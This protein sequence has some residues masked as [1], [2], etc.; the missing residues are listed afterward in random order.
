MGAMQEICVHPPRPTTLD[1]RKWKED[2]VWVDNLGTN[3]PT[4]Y[5][6]ELVELKNWMEWESIY[7]LYD[8]SKWTSHERWEDWVDL[9]VS[10]SLRPDYNMFLTL[11]HESGPI[12]YSLA[13]GR[14]LGKTRAYEVKEGCRIASD[15]QNNTGIDKKWAK[16]WC[17]DWLPKVNVFYCILAN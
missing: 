3:S 12:Y 11:I 17:K 16:V 7:M 4:K 15:H 10:I 6:Q 8:L 13:D 1:S 14:S 5:Q 2:K 9:E